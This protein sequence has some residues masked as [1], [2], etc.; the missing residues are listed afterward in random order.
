MV[1]MA[2][3]PFEGLV[4]F[5]ERELDDR[6]RVVLRVDPARYERL[7]TRSDLAHRS[8]DELAEW[9]A[10]RF[11]G[12]AQLADLLS[13]GAGGPEAL[14]GFTDETIVLLLYRHPDELVAIGVDRGAERALETFVD[15]CLATLQ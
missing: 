1:K 3:R 2:K 14:V 4:E 6:L 5:L 7:Y 12:A 13:G 8:D 10:R 11:P 15:R 9:F